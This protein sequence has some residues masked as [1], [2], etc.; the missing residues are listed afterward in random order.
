MSD[1]DENALVRGARRAAG[2]LARPASLVRR[3]ADRLILDRLEA[4]FEQ[5]ILSLAEPENARALQS[6][7]ARVA[8]VGMELG[9][10][11]DPDAAHLY[12]LVAWLEERHGRP[13]VLRR[14]GDHMA[15]TESSLLRTFESIALGYGGVAGTS[16]RDEAARRLHEIRD[17]VASD[18]LD[19]LCSLA[20]MELLEDPPTGS[21]ETRVEYYEEA[22]LPEE[23]RDLAAKAAGTPGAFDPP[24]GEAPRRNAKPDDV[25]GGGLARFTPSFDDPH[26]RFLAL[27]HVF[28]L[29]SYLARNLVEALPELLQQAGRFE[30]D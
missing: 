5:A 13:P 28:F 26:L 3:A 24:G 6:G 21:V 25:R 14:I 19:L 20:A 11:A 29:Q 1:R 2:K 10:K 27:S 15:A 9:F 18:L 4:R 17:V 23:F 16:A 12:E 7:L 30:Q 8:Q 22:C